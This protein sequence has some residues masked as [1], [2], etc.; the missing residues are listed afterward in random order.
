MDYISHQE[1]IEFCFRTKPLNLFFTLYASARKF[2]T[3]VVHCF[4]LAEVCVAIY[5]LSS[6]ATSIPQTNYGR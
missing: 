1:N 2:Q 5:S 4:K 6:R 3:E